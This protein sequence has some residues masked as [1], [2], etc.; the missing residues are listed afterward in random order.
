MDEYRNWQKRHNL[1]NQ[2]ESLKA[3]REKALN[4]F[5]NRS[6]YKDLSDEE[7]EKEFNSIFDSFSDKILALADLRNSLE[8]PQVKNQWFCDFV[9]SFGLC[10]S[11]KV[12]PKQAAIFYKYGEYQHYKDS[13]R[14]YGADYLC[15]VG[16]LFIKIS[17]FGE[18][19][20][21]YLTIKQ[22]NQF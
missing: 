18:N 11:R 5:Y 9:K 22:V 10:E 2:I 21:G 17:Y 6:D 4:A 8:Y 13:A 1:Y 7:E 16:D 14:I 20:T 19:Q 12:L 3:E 15:N